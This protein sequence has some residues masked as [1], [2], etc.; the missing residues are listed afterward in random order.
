LGY[1]KRIV[2][3]PGDAI[4]DEVPA[5]R[6]DGAQRVPPNRFVVLGDNRSRSFD[7]RRAGYIEAD[8]M[9]GVVVRRLRAPGRR[10][11]GS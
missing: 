1:V 9:L 2:A 6:A 3:L 5:L 10:Q 11:A 8:T 7:S 4:P